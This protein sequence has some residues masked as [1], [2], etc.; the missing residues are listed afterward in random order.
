VVAA[1]SAEH[2]LAHV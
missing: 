1:V 2:L